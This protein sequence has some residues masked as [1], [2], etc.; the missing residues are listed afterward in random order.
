MSSNGNGSHDGPV[1][2]P[3]SRFATHR[4]RTLTLPNG[5]TITVKRR[6]NAGENFDRMARMLVFWTDN[7]GTQRSRVD[8]T[9]VP[10]ETVI[11]YLVDWSGRGFLDEDGRPQAIRNESVEY[12]RAA[13]GQLEPE[14]LAEVFTAIDTHVSEMDAERATLKKTRGIDNASLA[15]SPSPSAAA[16]AS[17]GCEN[18]IPTNT[19]S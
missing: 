16:G 12:V 17:S 6:L 19:S 15:I 5:D 4:L 14:A 13:L 7:D 11:A 3:H 8:P 10:M 18:S 1:V 2:N 9:K